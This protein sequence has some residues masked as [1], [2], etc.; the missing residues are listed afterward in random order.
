MAGGSGCACVSGAGEASGQTVELD[1]GCLC[2]RL[3]LPLLLLRN[4]GDGW[5]G[6]DLAAEDY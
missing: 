3:A 4:V 1:L 6:G 5:R 2:C